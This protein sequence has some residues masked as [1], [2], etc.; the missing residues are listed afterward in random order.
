MM[1]GRWVSFWVSAYFQGLGETFGGYMFQ[2]WHFRNLLRWKPLMEVHGNP[3]KK[4]VDLL[5]LNWWDSPRFLPFSSMGGVSLAALSLV[6]ASRIRPTRI[7]RRLRRSAVVKA[8]VLPAQPVPEGIEAPP[9]VADPD[10]V[11][12]GSVGFSPGWGLESQTH[13]I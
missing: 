6:V 12:N 2:S 4:M 7:P 11:A 8:E 3:M 13:E 10:Q 9:Y 1:V 5:H